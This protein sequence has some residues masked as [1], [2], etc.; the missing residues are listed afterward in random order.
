MLEKSIKVEFNDVNIWDD[1][2]YLILQI[3]QRKEKKKKNRTFDFTATPPSEPPVRLRT[4]MSRALVPDSLCAS[5]R[6][7]AGL[8]VLCFIYKATISNH[9]AQT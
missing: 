3:L 8:C 2:G 7:L 4:G 5:R 9:R 1:G 6:G